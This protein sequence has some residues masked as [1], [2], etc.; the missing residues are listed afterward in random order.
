[1]KFASCLRPLGGLFF[2][3]LLPLMATAAL[4]PGNGA[5][6][7]DIMQHSS[8]C[9]TGDPI[10]AT[11][12]LWHAFFEAPATPAVAPGVTLTETT[13]LGSLGSFDMLY[14]AQDQLDALSGADM[15]TILNWVNAGGTL[16]INNHN[17]AVGASAFGTFAGPGYV[18][19]GI[20]DVDGNDIVVTDASH[21]LLTT[22][23]V[24]DATD[25]SNWGSSVHGAFSGLGPAYSC[26]ADDTNGVTSVTVL[27]SA[28]YGAGGIILT[29]FDPEC[30]SGCHDDHL[31]GG[32]NSGSEMWEN[33]VLFVAGGFAGPTAIPTLSPWALAVLAGLIGILAV[34]GLRRRAG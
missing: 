16:V 30:G 4:P 31:T 25:L 11:E 33:F 20:S 15:T 23:N 6:T 34:A 22:P 2:A 27:C 19:T 1:M 3:A 26:A 7:Y 29:G 12:S 21:P 32:T 8:C 5:A 28:T 10:A 14:I 18:F 9:Y 13:A 17:G 24:L